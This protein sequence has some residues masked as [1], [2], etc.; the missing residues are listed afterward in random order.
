[1]LNTYAHV[2]NAQVSVSYTEYPL[3]IRQSVLE[4]VHA[5]RIRAKYL[6]G[7]AIAPSR[8]RAGF[9]TRCVIK[10]GN[11]NKGSPAWFMPLESV[12]R[13]SALMPPFHP[14]FPNCAWLPLAYLMINILSFAG[15][16]FSAHGQWR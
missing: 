8:R 3:G 13:R 12:Q 16:R 7:F 14:L 2:L 6:D 11:F 5:Q 4:R 10:N 9:G 1:V 15:V